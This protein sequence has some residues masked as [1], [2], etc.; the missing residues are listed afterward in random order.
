MV[1]HDRPNCNTV[2]D[3]GK[4]ALCDDL[5]RAQHHKRSNER[6]TKIPIR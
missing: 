4:I 1:R 5:S 3:E 6:D 2:F